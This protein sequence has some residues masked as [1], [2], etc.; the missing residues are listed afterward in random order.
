MKS[1]EVAAPRML[2]ALPQR[3]ASRFQTQRL[4]TIQLLIQMLGSNPDSWFR[5]LG[6]P[7]GAMSRSDGAAAAWNRPATI[8]PVDP[9]HRASDIFAEGE[10]TASRF[11]RTPSSP[12]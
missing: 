10:I 8:Q 9:I 11:F 4:Q 6:Q 1:D 7:P 5:D 2:V 3:F 12:W